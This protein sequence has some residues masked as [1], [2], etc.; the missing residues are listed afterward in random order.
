LVSCDPAGTW[1]RAVEV[2]GRVESLWRYPVKSMRGEELPQAFVGFAGVCGDR[3]YA[4]RN[5]AAPK[6]FPYVTGRQR[7]DM[8]LYHRASGI[9]SMRKRRPISQSRRRWDPELRRSIPRQWI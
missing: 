4:F 1:G 5:S 6:G 8:L 2:V 9:R 3:F 7:T